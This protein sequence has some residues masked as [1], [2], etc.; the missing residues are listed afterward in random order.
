MRKSILKSTTSLVMSASLI[1]MPALAQAQQGNGNGNG[2]G[3]GRE[4]CVGL[5]PET[6]VADEPVVVENMAIGI[7]ELLAE[8]DLPCRGLDGEMITS[9]AEYANAITD[10]LAE[11]GQVSGQAETVEGEIDAA[12]TEAEPEEVAEAEAEAEAEVEGGAEVEA[13]VEVEAEAEAEAEAEVEAEAEAE[14]ET[15]VEVEAEAEAETEVETESETQA[16][17]ETETEAQEEVVVSSGTP[18]GN[19]DVEVIATEEPLAETTDEGAATVQA[20]T[21]EAEES[22]V[23]EATA[24]AEETLPETPVVDE[25][26][27]S[28]AAAAADSEEAEAEATAEVQTEEITA[29][30]V[31]SSDEDFSTS[32]TATEEAVATDTS[33][34]NSGLSNFERA[35]LLGLGAAVV[36]QV[37]NNGDQ[38]VSNSGDRVI[39][40]RDGELVV[41]KDD[42]VLLRQPGARVQTENF[43]D[44]STRTTVFRENGERIVT[45]RAADGRVLRRTRVLEDGREFV[46]FDDT[47]AADPVDVVELSLQKQPSPQAQASESDVETLR[48]ALLASQRADIDRTFSLRQIRQIRQVR[49]LA[50]EVELD[51]ITFASGSAAIAPDQARELIDLG[52]AISDI[53]EEDPSQVFLIEGH[54]DAVGNASYNLALSDRRAETVALALTEYFAIPPENLITQG[55]GESALKVQTLQ[56]ERANRRASVRNITSLLR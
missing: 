46:L 4:Y 45:I 53:I 5:T 6:E 8:V 14:A 44:G 3:N 34:D 36:G 56:A 49:E 52:Q 16:E 33:D 37:L 13:E 55:Y 23:G 19:E 51:T 26:P 18:E 35:L 29:E 50:P 30:D 20:E 32:A 11:E 48:A 7:E 27:A 21:P 41:L 9:T 10:R 38:V 15:E 25:A 42:D 2:N 17:A 39:V 43:N 22:Q 12:E 31:R 40:E 24:E 1:V 28:V 54:T 47:Q